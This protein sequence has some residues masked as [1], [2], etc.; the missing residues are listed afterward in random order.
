VTV[1]VPHRD[2]GVEAEAPATLHHLG[3]AID[4]DDVFNKPV[5]L[6]LALARVAALTPTPAPAPTPASAPP[7]A[8]P[9]TAAAAG[10][11]ATPTTTPAPAPTPT[12][13]H[14][15]CTAPLF[16][17]RITTCVRRLRFMRLG[18]GWRRRSGLALLL[19]H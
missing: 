10:T 18:G 19:I 16:D 6:A 12:P 8:A 3:D 7:A 14:G 2:E 13:T 4:G 15:G 5:P 11:A 1:P 9:G 17:A